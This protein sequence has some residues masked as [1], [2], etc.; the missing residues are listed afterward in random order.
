VEVTTWIRD[1]DDQL[2]NLAHVVRIRPKLIRALDDGTEVW[3]VLADVNGF[4]LATG[5]HVL[6]RGLDDR[7]AALRVI[8]GLGLVTR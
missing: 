5:P 8:K 2:L 1:A 7:E 3:D 4:A 6:A